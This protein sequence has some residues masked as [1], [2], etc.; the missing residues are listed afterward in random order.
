MSD[1]SHFSVWKKMFSLLLHCYSQEDGVTFP[2]SGKDCGRAGPGVLLLSASSLS[3]FPLNL[4]ALR[5]GCS[6]YL[7][8]APWMLL[9]LLDCFCLTGS[10]GAGW[11]Y[12][13]ASRRSG[14]PCMSS[15]VCS[16]PDSRVVGVE[17]DAASFCLAGM[18]KQ[19]ALK[20]VQAVPLAH[21]ASLFAGAH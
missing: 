18:Y 17:E 6:L 3:A 14:Q 20:A 15:S 4:L 9:L 16:V 1:T 13:E 12:S 2:R 8:L 5:A 21:E 11:D 10:T 7:G 19:A